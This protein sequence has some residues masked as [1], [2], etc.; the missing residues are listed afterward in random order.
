MAGK[1]EFF[2]KAAHNLY[3]VVYAEAKIKPGEVAK[4]KF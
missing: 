3:Q 4:Q 2:V 1:I